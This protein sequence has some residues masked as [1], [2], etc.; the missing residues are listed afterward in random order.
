MWQLP[1]GT[2]LFWGVGTVTYDGSHPCFWLL[3]QGAVTKLQ[4]TTILCLVSTSRNILVIGRWGM[5]AQ[6]VRMAALEDHL[7]T[8]VLSILDCEYSSLGRLGRHFFW[9]Q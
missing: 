7:I 8:M 2:C 9:G 4:E 3:L 6:V 1:S 5:V